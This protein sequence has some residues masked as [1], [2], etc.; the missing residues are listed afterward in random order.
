MYLSRRINYRSQPVYKAGRKVI[1]ISD[2]SQ[3]PDDYAALGVLCALHLFGEVEIIGAVSESADD[4]GPSCIKAILDFYGITAPVAAYQQGTTVTSTPSTSVRNQFKPGEVRADYP[5]CLLMREWLEDNEDVVII[6]TGGPRVLSRILLSSADVY[7][8]RSGTA[9]LNKAAAYIVMGG[10]FPGGS[11]TNFNI[12]TALW[13]AVLSTNPPKYFIGS[14]VGETVYSGPPSDASTTV[15]PIKNAFSAY[16]VSTRKSWDQCAILALRANQ[17]YS[18]V[19]GALTYSGG[20]NGFSTDVGYSHAYAV[21]SVS[22]ADISNQLNG[23]L[24]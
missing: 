2:I 13:P 5:D 20:S 11:E 17:V 12:S 19:T 7:S 6:N 22:D 3:D 18:W 15:N 21:K 8:N 4:Y 24:G 9:L 1:F 23:L 16:G 14:E 10:T